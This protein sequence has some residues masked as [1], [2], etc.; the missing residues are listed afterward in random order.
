MVSKMDSAYKTTGAIFAQVSTR[1]SP[2]LMEE[3]R[4]IQP[5]E[6]TVV[7]GTYD[8][9]EKLMDTLKVPYTLI[10]SAQ[11]AT[12][13]GSRVMLVNCKEYGSSGPRKAVQDFVSE[14]GRL[15]TT[16]WAL[17]LVSHAFPGKL[18]KVKHTVDDV[19]EIQ[20]PTDIARQW[21]GQN[22]AQCSPKWWLE[23][24]SHI[25]D[26]GQGV[27]PLITSEEMK[28]KYGKPYVAVGFTHG[29]GEVFHFISHLELQRTKH[30]TEADSAGLDTYLAKM[31]VE[32][33]DEME[34]AKVAEL[35][36]AFSTLNTLAHLCRRTPILGSSGKSVMSTTSSGTST[37]AAKSVPL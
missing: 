37:G 36:A 17:S 11:M 4:A 6:I 29:R 10:D 33:T 35:E 19:V 5:G 27:V 28:D 23:G 20:C 15:V 21:T 12:H 3:L 18:S 16:D 14:G 26:V 7:G 8:H 24:S 32:K 25:F 1:Q 31:G 9:I 30:K 2:G 34:D 22:Y 13:N